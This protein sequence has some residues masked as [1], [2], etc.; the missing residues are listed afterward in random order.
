MIDKIPGQN[1]LVDD[2][3]E[4]KTSY[5]AAKQCEKLDNLVHHSDKNINSANVIITGETMEK[6]G[7]FSCK[8][9]ILQIKVPRMESKELQEIKKKMSLLS[10]DYMAGLAVAFQQE[11]MKNYMKVCQTIKQYMTENL[12]KTGMNYDTRT[13]HHMT[14]IKLT[15][16]LFR[17]YMCNDLSDLSG[18]QELNKAIERNYQIQQR[19]LQWERQEECDNDYVRDVYLMLCGGNRYL[20]VVTN[21]IMYCPNNANF[22][23]HE[24]KSYVT[25]TALVNG[26][27]KY[28]KHA[29][30]WKKIVDAL[31]EAGVL[32][33]DDKVR[34]KK[35]VDKR[36]YVI[37]MDMIEDYLK[38]QQ[39]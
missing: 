30:S 13:Y 29:V 12:D 7:I 24:N 21:K 8:D 19:E 4:I 11:L 17:K 1:F 39:D 3:H 36:H 2:L 5:A 35:F 23:M 33:E 31:H 18:K 15:E 32:D 28:Y 22:Y 6:M 26:M 38:F 14:F 37:L 20:E 9:R 34:T 25:R 16:K 27:N 10:D